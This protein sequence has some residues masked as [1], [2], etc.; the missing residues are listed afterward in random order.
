MVSA[1]VVKYFL[2]ASLVY[3]YRQEGDPRENFES[4]LTGYSRETVSVIAVLGFVTL[5]SGVEITPLFE[6][7]SYFIATVYFGYLFWKF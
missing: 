5:L 1:V 4:I 7:P 6:L 2:V 3:A